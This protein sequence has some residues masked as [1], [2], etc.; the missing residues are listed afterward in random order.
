MKQLTEKEVNAIKNPIKGAN[1]SAHDTVAR[2]CGTFDF[3]CCEQANR[4]FL[5]DVMN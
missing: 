3:K 5:L 1:R 2:R 4:I